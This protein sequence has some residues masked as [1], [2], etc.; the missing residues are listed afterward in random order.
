MIDA[1]KYFHFH[2]R[3]CEFDGVQYTRENK[4]N[5][6]KN[7]LFREWEGQ[8]KSTIPYKKAKSSLAPALRN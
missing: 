2:I 8:H 1:S 4:I 6:P 7:Y 5:F 3:F